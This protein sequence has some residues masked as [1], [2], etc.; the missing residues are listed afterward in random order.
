M[1]PPER[2]GD[3]LI[4]IRDERLYRA[5]YATFGDYC[6][7]RWGMSRPRAYQLIES[8]STVS[9]L[10]DKGHPPPATESQDRLLAKLPPD[11]QPEAQPGPDWTSA[12]TSM[13]TSAAVRIGPGHDAR[14]LP[15]H[16]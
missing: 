5:A 8:A 11:E 12:R 16:P 4:A 7:E 14:G 15:E 1:P 2:P 9:T 10:V 6:R 13:Q 3:G